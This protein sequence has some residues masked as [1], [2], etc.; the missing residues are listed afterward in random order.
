MP[1][2]NER[3]L[4]KAKSIACDALIFDLEDAV[5]HVVDT[6]GADADRVAISET[7]RAFLGRD[8]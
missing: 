7:R 8:S 3:A 5:A 1:S 2:S 6:Y 4:E